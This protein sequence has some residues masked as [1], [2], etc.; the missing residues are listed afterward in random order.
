MWTGSTVVT[1]GNVRADLRRER[2]DLA[3]VVHA[4]LEHAEGG[5]PPHPGEGEG[6]AP[7]VIVGGDGGVGRPEPPEGEAHGLLGARL[8]DRPRHR[9]DPGA[10]AP[11][12]RAAEVPQGIQHVR[13]DGERA[14]IGEVPRAILRHEGG[15]RALAEGL[16]D[17]VVAVQGV[18]P[19][20]EEQVTRPER[21]RVDRDA[22]RLPD[23]A[24]EARARRRQILRLPQG[25]R[26]SV[27][28]AIAARTASWSENG[29]VRSPTIWPVS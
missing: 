3:R 20:G 13:H 24:D 8:A 26:H 28:S 5:V 15:R 14:G 19:D 12:R 6:H 22:A 7:M 10:A 23:R 21:P 16:A 11:A 2:R 18:A 4:D 1:T 25:L 17:E 27:T 29:S 9:D